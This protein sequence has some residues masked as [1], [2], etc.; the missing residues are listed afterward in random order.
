MLL[1]PTVREGGSVAAPATVRAVSAASVPSTAQ[2]PVGRAPARRSVVKTIAAS[3]SSSISCTR[4]RGYA[5]SI[6]TNA[7]PALLI[8]SRAITA[9]TC[10]GM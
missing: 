3:Q 8:A 2:G 9:S 1:G 4:A 6:G 5:V 7:P 10:R